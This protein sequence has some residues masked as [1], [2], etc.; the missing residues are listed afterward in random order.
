MSRLFVSY[1]RADKQVVEELVHTLDFLGHNGWSDASMRG[2]QRWWREIIQRI[3]DCDAFVVVLSREFLNS[4]ACKREREWA[5]SLGKP[6]LPIAVE[7]VTINLTPDLSEVHIVDYHEPG[8]KRAL[9]LAG[10]LASLP[11]APELPEKL[12]EPPAAP[13][14]YLAD[15]VKHVQLPVG[16]LN[17]EKQRT[18][19]GQLHRA[20]NS[21]DPEERQ[22]AAY[23]LDI[24]GRRDDL[25]ADVDRGIRALV[26]DDVEPDLL[27]DPP[28]V[29]VEQDEAKP[30]LTSIK[31]FGT[32]RPA[33]PSKLVAQPKPPEPTPPDPAPPRP[34]VAEPAADTGAA[35]YRVDE[36]RIDPGNPLGEGGV[37]VIRRCVA[38][39]DERMVFK[40]YSQEAQDKLDVAALRE[41]AALPA[42]L[43]AEDRERLL[44]ACAWPLAVVSESGS[45]VG[46]VM[47]EAPPEFFHERDA[48]RTPRHFTRVSVPEPIATKRGYEYFDFPHKIARLGHLLTDMQ[49]LHSQGI[50]LGDLQPNN[51]LTTGIASTNGAISTDNHILDCDSFLIHGRAALPHMDPLP[52]KPPYETHGFSTT[53]DMYKFALLVMRCLGED[54]SAG[55]IDF[56]RFGEIMPRDDLSK[57]TLLLTSPNPALESRDLASMARAWQSVV[58]KDGRMFRRTDDT[59]QERWTGDMRL[60]HLAGL[61]P[62]AGSEVARAGAAPAKVKS[63]GHRIAVAMLWVLGFVVL[64]IVILIAVHVL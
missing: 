30:G 51:I 23:I 60:K 2:G 63:G 1:A 48:I 58:K 8:E 5:N 24:F 46:V 10:A 18:I 53:T 35:E 47:R 33:E 15:I 21:V 17:Q 4:E 22:G 29:V 49:F 64:F 25:F 28:P 57:V 54:L 20:T 45:V 42:T 43:G 62:P 38:P 14:S 32:E 41:L 59:I 40:R 55:W 27:T 61:G 3:A 44:T 9:A 13:L 19:V 7:D 50:V 34:E 37:A 56:E 31:P 11:P 26:R 39:N 6:L 12:P 36:L 16:S 52:W